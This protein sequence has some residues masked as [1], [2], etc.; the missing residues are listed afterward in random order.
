MVCTF[1]ALNLKMLW[2][3]WGHLI[4]FLKFEMQLENG[5]LWSKTGENVGLEGAC[6]MHMAT[7]D[8]EHV[9]SS[10]GSFGAPF[11]KLGRNA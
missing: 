1:L 4:D 5:S 9:K 11:S 8:L 3:F 6:S 10:L 7:F 2:S